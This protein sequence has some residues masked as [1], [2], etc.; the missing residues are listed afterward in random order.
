ML[1]F[2]V[3][4]S[5]CA[6]PIPTPVSEDQGVIVNPGPFTFRAP[7]D[8]REQPA[9]GMDSMVGK[10]E[11]LRI[12]LS[13]D[14]GWYSD[15]L[16]GRQG[17]V[18]ETEEIAGKEARIVRCRSDDGPRHFKLFI[19]VHIASLGVDGRS[20]LT[21][22]AWCKDEAAVEVAR[23]IFRSIQFNPTTQS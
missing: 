9:V 6:T 21:M 1:L 17:A 15:S 10:Y 18:V 22:S 2:A 14:Y 8:L 16:M 20:R 11:G 3:M 4:L 23:S 13:F 7:P 5:A 12:S 19:G